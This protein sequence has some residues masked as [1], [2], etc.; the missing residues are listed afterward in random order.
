MK[1]IRPFAASLMLGGAL[2]L[3]S[4]TVAHTV[5]VTNN[6]VGSKSGQVRGADVDIDSGVTYSGAMRAGGIT[7]AGI[8]EYKYKNYVIFFREYMT[9]TGE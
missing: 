2:F 4:C 1:K 3:G 6:P 5:V 9:V 7:K 8:A